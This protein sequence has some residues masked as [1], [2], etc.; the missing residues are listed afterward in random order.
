MSELKEQVLIP[1]AIGGVL[2]LVFMVGFV[3]GYLVK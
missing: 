2:Y 3:M 1:L